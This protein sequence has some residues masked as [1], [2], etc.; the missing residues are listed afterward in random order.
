MAEFCFECWNRINKANDIPKRYIISENLSL[1]DGCGKYKH[2]VVMERRYYMRKPRFA[3]LPIK[4]I[5]TFVLLLWRFYISL[6]LFYKR[7]KE[8]NKVD[9]FIIKKD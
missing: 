3:V 7:K 4:F 5:C 2:I 9:D 6:Y 1:C 8:I